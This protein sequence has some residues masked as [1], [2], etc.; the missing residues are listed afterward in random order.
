MSARLRASTLSLWLFVGCVGL[1]GSTSTA[2]ADGQEAE[3][4]TAPQSITVFLVRH[5][6]KVR[7]PD[8]GRDPMLTEAGRARAQALAH[9]LA[10]ADID[11]IY[12]T[13]WRRT[14]ETGARL[15]QTL[16]IESKVIR[17]DQRFIDKMRRILLEQKGRRVVVVGHSD[18][19]PALARAL[20]AEEAPDIADNDFDDI[21]QLVISEQGTHFVHLRY[22]HPTP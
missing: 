9:T 8:V 18:T 2:L 11:A 12:T 16:D 5:A 1:M 20:G 6:E 17:A 3:S 19:T 7:G 15:A 4:R 14:I 21:Y 22:G 10:H 13:E